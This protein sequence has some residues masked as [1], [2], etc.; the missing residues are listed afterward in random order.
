MIEGNIEKHIILSGS[1]SIA[2]FQEGGLVYR[3]QAIPIIREIS[4]YNLE[5]D[6]NKIVRLSDYLTHDYEILGITSD[7]PEDETDVEKKA[8]DPGYQP[9]VRLGI[10]VYSNAKAV[11]NVAL[12]ITPFPFYN[13]RLFIN[14]RDTWHLKADRN[15]D[16]I[17]FKCSPVYLETPI[18]FP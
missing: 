17:S 18:A 2:A 3:S 9:A 11:Q 13:N 14:H 12:Q 4:I 5:K 6:R 1:D 7:I 8:T 15:V 16:R 10:R